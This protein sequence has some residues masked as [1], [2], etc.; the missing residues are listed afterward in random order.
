MK[1]VEENINGQ[2]SILTLKDFNQKIK[3]ILNFDKTNKKYNTFDT[4]ER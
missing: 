3:I 1:K 4:I 2:T